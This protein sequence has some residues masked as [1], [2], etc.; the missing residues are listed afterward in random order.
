MDRWLLIVALFA[1]L[2]LGTAHGA[3]KEAQIADQLVPRQVRVSFATEQ[4]FVSVRS[5]VTPASL[6]ETSWATWDRDGGRLLLGEAELGPLLD[7]VTRAELGH[8]GVTVDGTV[9]PV[10]A[11]R[12]RLEV[13]AERPVARCGPRPALRG[14]ASHG[15]RRG[16][17]PL[18]RLRSAP[19]GGRVVPFRVSFGRGLL[20]L[21]GGGAGLRFEAEASASR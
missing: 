9:V 11:L 7:S 18:R 1:A 17:T 20:A 10:G 3:G 16:R 14:Q 12:T 2:P 5:R 13:P 8:L 21:G 6:G 19:Q 4:L 15:P